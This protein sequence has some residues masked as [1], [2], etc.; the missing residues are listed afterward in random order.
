M[1]PF[2]CA[3]PRLS[4]TAFGFFRGP[5]KMAL[6]RIRLY[7]AECGG[8]GNNHHFTTGI[9]LTI[10]KARWPISGNSGSGMVLPRLIMFPSSALQVIEQTSSRVVI[11]DPPSYARAAFV[12]IAALGAPL[13]LLLL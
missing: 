6:W 10:S 3:T 11:L 4:F 8:Q 12:V 5:G 9:K 7:S 2:L 13:F 1:F